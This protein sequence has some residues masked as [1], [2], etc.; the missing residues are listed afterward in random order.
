VRSH[1]FRSIFVVVGRHEVLHGITIFHHGRRK[2]KERGGPVLKLRGIY[3]PNPPPNGDV[4]RAPN[5]GA[6]D[7]N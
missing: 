2:K 7:F 3:L 6:V 5:F 4:N 1:Y